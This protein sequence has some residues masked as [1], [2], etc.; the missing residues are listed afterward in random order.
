VDDATPV[1]SERRGRVVWLLLDGP[2]RRNALGT[3]TVLD[4][5]SALRAADAD[6][7]VGAIVITGGGEVFSAGADLKEFQASLQG[8]AT[9]HWESGA[10]WLELFSLIPTMAKPVIAA[11]NGPAL[12]GGCGLVAVC[13][14]AIASTRATFATPEVNI[15]LFPLFIL[16][17]LVRAVGRRH[18]LSLA[19]TGRTIDA[20]EAH[21]IG[22]VN[23][24]VEAD[25]FDSLVNTLAD[26]LATKMPYTMALGKHVF[27]RIAEAD[28]ATGLELARAMRG[29]FL[30]S[31]DLRRGTE[32]FFG[33]R[34]AADGR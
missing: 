11:A 9:E 4:L 13:D 34:G 16:P 30:A 31:D 25:Q 33:R 18:A 29:A 10:P 2:E 14:L 3:R 17:A 28:Y 27:S 1:K 24:V 19:M 26:N 5:T 21:R 22:L 23:S 7:E 8:S 12:A 32:S 20:V 15:G 6:T